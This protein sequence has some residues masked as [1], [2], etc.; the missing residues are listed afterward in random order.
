MG[1]YQNYKNNKIIILLGNMNRDYF[2]TKNGINKS[3]LNL[4][5]PNKREPIIWD[6]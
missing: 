5:Y 2:E 1:F 4:I 6:N 3:F